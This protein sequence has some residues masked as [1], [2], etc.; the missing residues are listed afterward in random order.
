MS[1]FNQAFSAA[2]NNG[3]NPAAPTNSFR[4][5]TKR[6]AIAAQCMAASIAADP[7]GEYESDAHA[8]MAVRAAD[9]LLLQLQIEVPK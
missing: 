8:R 2:Q 7:D 9:A 4:G 5:M 6:E 3:G 1:D